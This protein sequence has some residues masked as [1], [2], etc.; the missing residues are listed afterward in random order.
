MIPCALNLALRGACPF[1]RSLA[2][3]PVRSLART[4][5][6]SLAL[7]LSRSISFSPSL[8]PLALSISRTASCRSVSRL[9]RALSRHLVA[10]SR[11]VVRAGRLVCAFWII[12][13]CC[14]DDRRWADY[15]SIREPVRSPVRS[16]AR[17]PAR[18][19]ARSLARSLAR[20]HTLACARDEIRDAAAPTAGETGGG[21]IR[22]VLLTRIR[23][24][25]RRARDDPPCAYHGPPRRAD[26]RAA[27]SH[28]D[29]SLPRWKNRTQHSLS[30]KLQN[31]GKA[32]AVARDAFWGPVVRRAAPPPSPSALARG[33]PL[34][35]H[36]PLSNP[37]RRPAKGN[38]ATI[39]LTGNSILESQRRKKK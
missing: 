38:V 2:R 27:L 6:H 20:T 18:S 23:D 39:A 32:H 3:S 17:P 19:P 30:S 11:L 35:R 22:H 5:A 4:F 28:D 24:A 31:G 34:P 36:P 26:Q 25:A 21:E 14:L 29:V 13:S 12:R 16:P 8:F 15:G 9:E 1:A 10:R 7:A 33:R 37:T